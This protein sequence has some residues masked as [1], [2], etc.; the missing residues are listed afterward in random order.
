MKEL[1]EKIK[2]A[3]AEYEKCYSEYY[4][5]KKVIKR[6]Y[7]GG[8]K[9][10]LSEG[11][12]LD[13]LEEKTILAL[14]KYNLLKKSYSPLFECNHMFVMKKCEQGIETSELIFKCIKCQE[15]IIKKIAT[16]DMY[17]KGYDAVARET[18]NNFDRPVYYLGAFDE[19]KARKTYIKKYNKLKLMD[20]STYYNI[21]NENDENKIVNEVKLTLNKK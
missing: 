14:D 5:L 8:Y 18:L 2:I 1:L 12:K 10:T 6:K 20:E 13:F 11:K 7:Q 19:E 3:K 21:I 16:K 17:L 15:Y 4:K 9:V